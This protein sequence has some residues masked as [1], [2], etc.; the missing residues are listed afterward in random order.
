[1]KNKSV[2]IGG[3][4]NFTLPLLKTSKYFDRDRTRT[5]NPQIR[6]LVPYPLGH[7]VLD[8]SRANFKQ[9]NKVHSKI[10]RNLYDSVSIVNVQALAD[11]N[12]PMQ[13]FK[14]VFEILLSLQNGQLLQS[15]LWA[16]NP[17]EIF[18]KR[19]HSNWLLLS[20]IFEWYYDHGFDYISH[21]GQNCQ[22]WLN[23]LVVWFL[24][25]VQEV[26]GSNPGWAQEF[27]RLGPVPPSGWR[28]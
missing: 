10:L 9:E 1:M 15:K 8:T 26:P 23:G 2:I 13:K 11:G 19:D 28:T 22:A 20:I 18:L 14:D 3:M 4:L 21:I 24:L 17:N 12:V 27:C 6:S 5:C 7:T 16:H 25:R